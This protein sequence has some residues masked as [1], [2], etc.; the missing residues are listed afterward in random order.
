MGLAWFLLSCNE[1]RSDIILKKIVKNDTI[2]EIEMTQDSL[3]HGKH[4]VFLKSRGHLIEDISYNKGILNGP[5]NYYFPNGKVKLSLNYDHG[6]VNGFVK[7]YDSSGE[8]S[9]MDYKHFDVNLGDKI[10]FKDGKPIFYGFKAPFGG[11]LFKWDYLKDDINSKIDLQEFFFLERGI[12]SDSTSKLITI[13]L[14]NPPLCKFQYSYYKVDNEN[15]D[16]SR[17]IELKSDLPF[18]ILQI[19]LDSNKYVLKLDLFN[20]NGEL[21]AIMHKAL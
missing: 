20:E 9:E 18:E 17:L 10:I 4:K 5:C 11:Y 16:T 15:G 3:Y 14:I 8:L 1:T 6:F 7:I 19:P 12:S 21:V 2:T 13:F